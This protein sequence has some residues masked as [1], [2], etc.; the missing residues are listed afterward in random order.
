MIISIITGVFIYINSFSQNLYEADNGQFIN[1][2]GEIIFTLPEKY[3]IIGEYREGYMIVGEVR[4]VLR[5]KDSDFETCLLTKLSIVNNRGEIK[6]LNDLYILPMSSMEPG[7]SVPV[8]KN[9]CAVITKFDGTS[10][11]IDKNGKV[12]TTKNLENLQKD[13]LVFNAK[14]DK[15]IL[16]DKK[17]NTIRILGKNPIEYIASEYSEGT[18]AIAQII[19]GDTITDKLM[20]VDAKGKTFLDTSY[21]ALYHYRSDWVTSYDAAFHNGLALVKDNDDNFLYIDRK[22]NPVIRLKTKNCDPYNFIGS[23]AN[24][25][26]YNNLY[27]YKITRIVYINKKGE[28]VYTYKQRRKRPS[29]NIDFN[30]LEKWQYSYKDSVCGASVS[31]EIW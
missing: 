31:Q 30:T 17:G 12:L 4:K 18:M 6:S 8:F 29:F 28:E 23:L 27:D 24:I 13:E 19:D 10:V 15:Y 5:L 21:H 20:Y 26:Y 11:G 1:D 14:D 2:K 3:N 7:V 16:E 22:G 25:Y 9:G